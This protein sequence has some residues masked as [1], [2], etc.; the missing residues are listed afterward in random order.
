MSLKPEFVVLLQNND[1]PSESAIREVTE[2]L[3]APLNELG[4]IDI[5]IQRLGELV[6]NLRIKRQN[7]QKVIDDHNTILSPVRRLP[8]DV[9]FFFFFF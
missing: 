7:I 8:V 6:E 1:I 9:F 2:S 4:K 5:E 3:K